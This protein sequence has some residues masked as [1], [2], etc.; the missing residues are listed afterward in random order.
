MGMKLIK[1]HVVYAEGNED[2]YT[3]RARTINSGFKKALALAVKGV[4]GTNPR[5]ELARIEFWMVE[6]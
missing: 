1:Y 2:F 3:V 5:W 4:E 6:S